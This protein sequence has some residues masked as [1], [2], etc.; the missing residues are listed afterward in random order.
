MEPNRTQTL[1]IFE[2]ISRPVAIERL[3]QVMKA[4]TDEENCMCT[5]AARLGI[6]C[7]GFR[8]LSDEEF[9]QRFHWIARKRPGASREEL[10]RLVSLYHCGR[11]RDA[12]LTQVGAA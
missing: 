3:R 1:P 7:K 8:H 11:Q 5:A 9:R 10:E 12:E 2:H 4:L 6:F